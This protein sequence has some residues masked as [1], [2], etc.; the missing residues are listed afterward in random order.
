MS[1]EIGIPQGEEEQLKE[2]SR[3]K[4]IEI[5]QKTLL[6]SNQMEG[7]DY[8]DLKMCYKVLSYSGGGKNYYLCA[9]TNIIRLEF[10][11]K[12][13]IKRLKTEQRVKSMLIDTNLH[14]R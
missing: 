12:E 1:I 13:K 5:P 14:S 7:Q 2:I 3:G 9:G 10:D 6:I 4:Q 8:K 11:G